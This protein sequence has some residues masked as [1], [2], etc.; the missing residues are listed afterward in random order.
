MINRQYIVDEIKNNILNINVITTVYEWFT[1]EIDKNELPIV[2]VKDTKEEIADRFIESVYKALS[3]E[4]VLIVSNG[5]NTSKELRTIASTI[6]TSIKNLDLEI[7]INSV[8]F[9]FDSG[10]DI[11]GGALINMTVLYESN[12]F[13]V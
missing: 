7:Q 8:E 9:S 6:L 13:E 12:E 10:E 5:T 2:I 1:D 4:L 11:Q 3:I